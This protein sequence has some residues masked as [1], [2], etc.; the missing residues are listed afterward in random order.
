MPFGSG[1]MDLEMVILSEV[2]QTEKDKSYESTNIWCL[3]EMIQWNLQNRNRLKDFETAFI[4]TK[5]KI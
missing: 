3:I 2:R 4:F 1:W 5:G